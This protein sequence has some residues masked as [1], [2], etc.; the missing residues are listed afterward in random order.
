MDPG[1]VGVQPG[2]DPAVQGASPSSRNRRRVCFLKNTRPQTRARCF[3]FSFQYFCKSD[4]AP[5]RRTG[6]LTKCCIRPCAQRGIGPF[7]PLLDLPIL[8][9]SP[10]TKDHAFGPRRP[11]SRGPS[12]EVAMN[13]GRIR[14]AP[15]PRPHPT[16][17]SAWGQQPQTQ[18]RVAF[19]GTAAWFFMR[20]IRRIHG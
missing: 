1:G 8:L 17:C 2:M 18:T 19:P 10:Q 9:Q 11:S 3:C 13:K 7:D 16:P 14:L 15:P 4:A 20:A 5:Q 6:P 12:I